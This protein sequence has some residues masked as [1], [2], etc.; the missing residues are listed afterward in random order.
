MKKLLSVTVI[1]C[2]GTLCVIYTY[3]TYMGMQIDAPA[4]LIPWLLL[5]ADEIGRY[6]EY[7]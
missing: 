3:K 6:G 2:S 1:L 7:K 5:L 4:A